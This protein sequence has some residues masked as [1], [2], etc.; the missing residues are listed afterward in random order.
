MER[1]VQDAGCE[2]VGAA[3]IVEACPPDVRRLLRVR[4]LLH[5]RE[6]SD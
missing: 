2:Y 1:I 3:V 5:I 4:S 6:L